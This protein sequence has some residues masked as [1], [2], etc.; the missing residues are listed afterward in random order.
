MSTNKQTFAEKFGWLTIIITVAATAS[1]CGLYDNYYEEGGWKKVFNQWV[2]AYLSM[3]VV[4]N[5][6]KFWVFYKEKPPQ[7]KED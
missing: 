1:I 2:F 5:T 4:H 3:V 6:Q 7:D